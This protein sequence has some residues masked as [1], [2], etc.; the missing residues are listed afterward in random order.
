[1]DVAS[2]AQQ[3]RRFIETLSP[4]TIARYG[5]LAAA[6]VHF[7]DP[8]NDAHGVAAARRVL[9]RTFRDVDDPRYTVTHAAVDGDTCFLRWK[10]T[11][12]PRMSGLGQ[13]WIID[14]ITEVRFNADGKVIEHVDYWDAGHYVYERLPLFGYLIRF[15]RKRMATVPH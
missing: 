14:G 13:P 9:A 3:Y 5:E 7:R 10:F 1:M 4:E 11:C 2:A 8:L 15:L 12:R 6:N